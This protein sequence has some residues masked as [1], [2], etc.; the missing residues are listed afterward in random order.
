MSARSNFAP[1][2]TLA[3][4]LAAVFAA[5]ASSLVLAAEPTTEPTTKELLEQIK[6][7]QNKVEQLETKQN[8]TSADVAATVQQIVKDAE[9]RSQLLTTDED[10]LAGHDG[11]TFFLKSADGNY[12]VIPSLEMQIRNTTNYDSA[13]DGS[14]ENGFEI[15]RFWGRRYRIYG[16]LFLFRE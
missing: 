15:R 13:G 12:L 4:S 2:F 16:D 14:T 7:L 10:F 5:S 8:Q 9:K 11:K 1:K 6:Q 3:A